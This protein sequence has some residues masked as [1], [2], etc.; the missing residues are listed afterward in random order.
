MFQVLQ[1]LFRADHNEEVIP[2]SDFYS[3]AV[4]EHASLEVSW[5]INDL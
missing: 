3:V 1:L 5:S 4:S 2:Y